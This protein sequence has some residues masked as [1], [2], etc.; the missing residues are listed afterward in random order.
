[1]WKNL[2]LT[3]IFTRAAPVVPVTNMRYAYMLS[4]YRA[5]SVMRWESGET[6]NVPAVWSAYCHS[7]APFSQPLFVCIRK[8]ELDL[9][10]TVARVLWG[11]Q[12]F[13]SAKSPACLAKSS[14]PPPQLLH[15]RNPGNRSDPNWI[16]G[17]S[18]SDICLCL[19]L[20]KKGNP[21]IYLC[22]SQKLILPLS[23][24]DRYIY[25]IHKYKSESA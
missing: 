5:L 16:E 20:Y 18:S 7:H 24:F 13:W 12:G 1:M 6:K 8:W 9:C 21:Q 11:F 17:V 25:V 2:H 10:L 14:P 22:I 4:V 19:N 15:L 23:M 3:E